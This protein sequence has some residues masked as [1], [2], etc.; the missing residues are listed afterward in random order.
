MAELD[1][2]EPSLRS[3]LQ[4]LRRRSHWVVA[5][6]I[7]AV[8]AS[9]GYSSVQKKEYSATAQLLA[10]PSSGT[11]PLS[12]TQQTVSPTDVLTDLQLITGETVKAQ[13]SK[14]LG[15]T[16]DISATQVGETNVIDVTASAATPNLAAHVANTY[17]QTFVRH[18]RMNAV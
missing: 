16:P 7:L 2:P 9:V 10:Q 14:Q 12:G 17:A 4:V 1:S 18:Q 13:V 3:F 6:V 8:A 11:V 15:F 5:F